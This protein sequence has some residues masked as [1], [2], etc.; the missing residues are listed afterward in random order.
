MAGELEGEP[1]AEAA[2]PRRFV[3]KRRCGHR[4]W[5]LGVLILAIAAARAE[6][7]IRRSA[8]GAA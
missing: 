7:P 8:G 2:A 4:I 6:G 1:A 3:A 5:D